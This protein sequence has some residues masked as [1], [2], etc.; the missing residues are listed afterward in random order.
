MASLIA[1]I[2]YVLD[3]DFEVV[4]LSLEEFLLSTTCFS[5]TRPAGY[6]NCLSICSRTLFLSRYSFH[7]L[8]ASLLSEM[9]YVTRIRLKAF[10]PSLLSII[11]DTF[12]WRLPISLHLEDLVLRSYIIW[13]V[14]DSHLFVE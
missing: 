6:R 4:K 1:F 3:I 8:A 5:A 11:V 9:Q 14:N 7:I 2:H 12:D 10:L 13:R